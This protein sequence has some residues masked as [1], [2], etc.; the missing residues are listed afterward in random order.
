MIKRKDIKLAE[1]GV[2]RKKYRELQYF[3]L[4]YEEK[5]EAALSGFERKGEHRARVQEEKRERF[6]KEVELIEQTAIEA[7]PEIYS[8]LLQSVTQGIGYEYMDVP[9][10]KG[11]FYDYRKLFFVLLAEKR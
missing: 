6:R 7:N 10:S 3:C 4:Q 5:K 11:R 9:M 2:S 1:L 8:Y